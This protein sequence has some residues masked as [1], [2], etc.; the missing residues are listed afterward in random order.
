[1]KAYEIQNRRNKITDLLLAH[2]KVKVVDLVDKFQVSDETIRQ[3]LV[4]LEKQGI[5]KKIYGGAELLEQ[6]QLEPV[7]DRTPIDHLE[8]Q[9]IVNAASDLIPEHAVT[10]GLDQGSTIAMLANH[11]KSY[12]NKMIFT[13]SLAAILELVRSGNDL[14]CFGG[15]Y[16]YSD[17]SFQN[18][19]SDE[20][21]PDIKLDLC[22]FGSSGVLNRNGFC[23]SSFTDAVIK[24]KLLE[25]SS[26]KIVLLDANKFKTSSLIEV[27]P[28]SDVDLVISNQGIPTDIQASIEA[29]TRLILV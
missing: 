8:K 17:M 14:Y 20:L 18:D 9:A 19:T 15:K 7:I 1:M 4:Y 22:F 16:A 26:Q 11:L 2:Q 12:Q 28:W 3:D 21:Y 6:K 29:Q 24:R 10:I 13:G 5:L 25:K 23:T 27:A